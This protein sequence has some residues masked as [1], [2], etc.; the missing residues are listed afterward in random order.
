MAGVA[1]TA[2]YS[3]LR[4]ERY[5]FDNP[6]IKNGE[7]VNFG[8]LVGMD[9][10]GFVVNASKTAGSVVFAR[11]VAM[12]VDDNS[13]DTYLTGDGTT[14][15]C[16]ISRI[17]VIKRTAAN[18]LNSTIVPGLAKGARVYL[19]AL[20]TATVSNYTCTQTSTNGDGLQ[21]VGFVDSSGLI[22]EIDVMPNCIAYQT[23]G[24]SVV[25]VG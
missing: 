20:G 17:A 5:F 21:P 1:L 3:G 2:P 14:V 22:L 6:L 19:G 24:N 7:V 18:P 12:P 9:S 10:N 4:P 25:G 16:A 23:S 11:G 15:R 8:D 13:T